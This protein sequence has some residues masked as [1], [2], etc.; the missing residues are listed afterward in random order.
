M[1]VKFLFHYIYLLYLEP[2]CTYIVCFL[3][4][5][6]IVMSSADVQGTFL[7]IHRHTILFF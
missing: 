1:T 3:E 4:D 6:H 7:L 2:E 5:V